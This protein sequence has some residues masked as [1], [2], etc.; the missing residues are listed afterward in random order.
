MKVDT[1]SMKT[2]TNKRS[3]R[4]PLAL[5]IRIEFHDEQ[6]HEVCIAGTF[7]DWRP[8]ATP[9]R[10]AGAGDWA[11]DLSLPAGRYEYRFVVDEQWR[12]DPA[13][14]SQVPNGFGSFNS[15]VEV[16]PPRQN[17]TLGTRGVRPLDK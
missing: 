17:K 3:A 2:R 15:V 6:A 9:M 7:N 8:D 1:C 13:A 16:R 11:A 5:R 14:A 12:N 10:A 4:E